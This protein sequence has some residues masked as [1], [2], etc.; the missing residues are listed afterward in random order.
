MKLLLL[1]PASVWLHLCT[2]QPVYITLIDSVVK[3][4]AARPVFYCADSLY[5]EFDRDS[6]LTKAVSIGFKYSDSKGKS[7][8]MA[9]ELVWDYNDTC[10]IQ[11]FFRKNRLIKVSATIR[12]GNKTTVQ[13]FYFN[14]DRLVFP[15]H[16]RNIFEVDAYIKKSKEY[17]KYR[18]KSVY[19]NWMSK[20]S[21][22]SFYKGMA[23]KKIKYQFFR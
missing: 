11:Y 4:I 10:A 8:I 23:S 9:D 7:L 5:K 16:Y 22:H 21:P 13:H 2:A 6:N 19:G 18:S 15:A 3:E 17:V 1:I 20:V 14:K 12:S